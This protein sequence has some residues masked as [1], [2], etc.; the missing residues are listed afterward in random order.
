MFGLPASFTLS[1][2]QVRRVARTP[3]PPPARALPDTVVAQ[4]LEPDALALLEHAW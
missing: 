3:A 2:E 4:L 1:R